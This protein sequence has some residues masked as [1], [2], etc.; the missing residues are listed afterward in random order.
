LSNFEESLQTSFDGILGFWTIMKVLGYPHLIS[1]EKFQC[2]NFDFIANCLY[3]LIL[4][5][6]PTIDLE[7]KISNEESQI[8]FIKSAAKIMLARAKIKINEKNIY[9]AD[10]CA[11][12][13][14]LKIAII[15]QVS[16]RRTNF[17]KDELTSKI[18]AKQD[19]LTSKNTKVLMVG[20]ILSTKSRRILVNEITTCGTTFYDI[21]V[22]EPKL[23]VL[24]KNSFI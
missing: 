8:N 12:K 9:S 13:E 15:L 20:N 14:L 4:R 17:Q 1:I 2:P 7:K 21:L 16:S 11:I 24:I 6:D 10:G 22:M 5:F 19:D 18:E 23:K 3:W